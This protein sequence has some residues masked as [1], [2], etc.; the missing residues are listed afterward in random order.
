MKVTKRTQF[1]GSFC[2]FPMLSRHAFLSMRHTLLYRVDDVCYDVASLSQ[3]FDHNE[4]RVSDVV[5]ELMWQV[6]QRTELS[7]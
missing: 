2:R 5:D 6:P 3:V 1:L 7:P 4:V